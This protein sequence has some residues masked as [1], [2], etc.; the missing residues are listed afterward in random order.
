VES[1]VWVLRPCKNQVMAKG[2][3]AFGVEGHMSQILL[4]YMPAPSSSRPCD[5]R[6]SGSVVWLVAAASL[7]SVC[8]VV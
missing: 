8:V 1:L 3:N 6:P 4:Q 2:V 7:W 5:L